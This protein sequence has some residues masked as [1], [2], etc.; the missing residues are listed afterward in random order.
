MVINYVTVH[1]HIL[2][3]LIKLSRL[4]WGEWTRQKLSIGCVSS[5]N[6]AI[7]VCHAKLDSLTRKPLAK[8]LSSISSPIMFFL[9]FFPTPFTRQR[10]WHFPPTKVEGCLVDV[11]LDELNTT[12]SGLRS[13][14][15]FNYK[16]L[17]SMFHIIKIYKRI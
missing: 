17:T 10:P 13:Y 3:Q 5:V 4:G 11:K 9:L 7:W 15:N 16:K 8:S 1:N 2:R 14:F 6:T 12:P